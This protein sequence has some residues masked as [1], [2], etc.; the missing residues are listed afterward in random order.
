MGRP[1]GS[2]YPR[3]RGLSGCLALVVS[4]ALVSGC[5]SSAKQT[6]TGRATSAT[7]TT[8]S[9]PNAPSH[10]STS[11]QQRPELASILV[12]SPA[13]LPSGRFDTHYSCKGANT[14]PPLEWAGMSPKAKEVVVLVR[15][16]TLGLLR[17]NWIVAGISPSRTKIGA[18][19]VPPEGIVG[20]NSFGQDGY[21]LCP[22]AGK[23]AL[24]VLAVLGIPRKLGLHPGF[25]PRGVTL[26][27][28][29]PGV[30]WG[31]LTATLSKSENAGA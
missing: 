24:I 21:S 5:G 27:L 26:L 29:T 22:P 2:L 28:G 8:E 15:T 3:G 7:Q 11:P 25:N 12:A 4:L 1:A 20:R 31:S 17:T 13:R 19:E 10:V 18:G 30:S 9:V 23:S 6:A 14:S 16:L